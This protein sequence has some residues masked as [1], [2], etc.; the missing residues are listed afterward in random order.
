VAK[1]DTEDDEG[2]EPLTQINVDLEPSIVSLVTVTRPGGGA[3]ISAF[4]ASAADS[5]PS[6]LEPQL[7]VRGLARGSGHAPG[8]VEAPAASGRREHD[9]ER[10]TGSI[11]ARLLEAY[12]SGRAVD[13]ASTQPNP[14]HLPVVIT[15]SEPFRV[16]SAQ[17]SEKP[18]SSQAATPRRAAPIPA[19]GRRP[20]VDPD[21][22]EPT[23]KRAPYSLADHTFDEIVDRVDSAATKEVEDAEHAEEDEED[24]EDETV[25]DAMRARLRES[26]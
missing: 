5:E 11:D 14:G 15:P 10:T 2:A 23:V 21:M 3:P 24:E 17:I 26:R 18:R 19:A 4:A 6:T 12:G 16:T 9:D 13:D 8:S 25:T 1:D 22:A 7:S 20:E